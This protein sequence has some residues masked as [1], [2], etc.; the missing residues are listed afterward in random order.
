MHG[1]VYGIVVTTTQ[2][3]RKATKICYVVGAYFGVTEA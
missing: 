2:K 3:E 1:L